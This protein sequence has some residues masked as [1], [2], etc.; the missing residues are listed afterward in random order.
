VLTHLN[1]ELRQALKQETSDNN[2]GMDLCLC[3][4]EKQDKSNTKLIY[5][6]A[7]RPLFIYR[8]GNT[9]LETIEG[10][11]VSIGGRSSGKAN[12]QFTQKEIVINTDDIIYLSSDG[13]IDQNGPDRMRFG[14]QRFIENIIK[15]INLPL[16][17]QKVNLEQTL[18]SYIQNEEQRDDI[19]VLAI[20]MI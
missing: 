1:N 12:I 13:F 8:K 17:E 19:T 10:D 14:T 9:L 11:R 16:E 3:L 20:K 7:K 6:G 5:A 2:D 18:N 4:L 15:N